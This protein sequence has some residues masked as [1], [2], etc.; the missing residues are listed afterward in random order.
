MRWP[1]H[2][3]ARRDPA[4]RDEGDQ[5]DA[6]ADATARDALR[7]LRQARDESLHAEAYARYWRRQREQNHFTEMLINLIRG[8]K[9]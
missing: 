7:R 4:R 2:R 3:P 6:V 9:P 1:W 5:R 8:A